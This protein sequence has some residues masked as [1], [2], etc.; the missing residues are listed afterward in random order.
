M[1]ETEKESFAERSAKALEGI[2]MLLAMWIEKTVPGAELWVGENPDR[3]LAGRAWRDPEPTRARP[4]QSTAEA[5]LRH[6][7]ERLDRLAGSLTALE[8]RVHEELPD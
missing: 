2:E 6:I 8:S 1:K 4:A 3:E 7:E 5:R